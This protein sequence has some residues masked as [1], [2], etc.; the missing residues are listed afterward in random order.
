MKT[1]K[2]EF[3]EEKSE[4]EKRKSGIIELK[5]PYAKYRRPYGLLAKSGV[6]TSGMRPREAWEALDELRRAEAAAR[7]Q[8]QET[9]KTPTKIKS[10]NG[11]TKSKP[12]QRLAPPQPKNKQKVAV[13]EL[14][15]RD[16]E[17][18][19]SNSMFDRG[20]VTVK[21]YKSYADEINGWD[22]SLKQKEKLISQLKKKFDEKLSVDARYVPWTVSGPA[23]YNSKKMNGLAE[24]GM[25]HSADISNW[26]EGVERSVKNSSRQYQDDRKTEAKRKEEEFYHLMRSMP[27][28]GATTVATWLTPIAQYDPK[29]YA[30]LYE[31]YD[32]EYHFRKNTN[33]A[34]LYDKVKKGEYTGKKLPKK[35]MESDSYNAYKKTIQS[36]ERV[37][38]KFTTK[39]KPQLIYALKRRGW[40]WNSLEEA[41]SVPVDK[42]DADFVKDI[43][44]RYKKYL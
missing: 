31:K 20:D 16:R 24:R 14:S 39:P 21:A 17:T 42:Y 38:M 29:R 6:S 4:Q 43:E 41:W 2:M 23:G 18:A 3:G 36:G 8:E 35:L 26:F 37:F 22:I 13:P 1:K 28:M 33:A 32:K 11:M 15:E 30:E 34:K 25:R 40:H 7:R 10:T 44:E 19:N 27:N 9:K 5:D 12:E